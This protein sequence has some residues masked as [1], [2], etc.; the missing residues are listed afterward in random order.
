MNCKHIALAAALACG[1]NVTAAMADR[2]SYGGGMKD[3]AVPAPVLVPAPIPVPEH[4]RW[5]IRADLGVS[6]QSGSEI[7]EHGMQYGYGDVDPT[8]VPLGMD[9]GWFSRN[10]DTMVMGGIGA[11]LYFSP[12]W[13]G[14]ITADVRQST[15][16]DGKGNRSYLEYDTTVP[17]YTGNRIDAATTDRTSVFN[18]VVLANLYYDFVDRGSGFT[19]YVGIGGGLV[20]RSIDREHDTTENLYDGSSALIGA[21]TITGKG[22][23]TQVAPA[24]AATAGVAYALSPSTIIDVNYRFTYMGEVDSSITLSNG[25]VSKISIGDAFE[26]TVRAGIRWNVW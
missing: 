15:D 12:R 26:H 21:R 6:F 14:D 24:A 9:S 7:S 16:S 13:R 2:F 23:S 20:V 10:T 25:T 18:T 1:F 19:P 17:G 5:Y 8:R 22:K 3:Y 4:F 11:G